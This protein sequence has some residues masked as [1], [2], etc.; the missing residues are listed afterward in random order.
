MIACSTTL[1]AISFVIRNVSHSGYTIV[2]ARQPR[3]VY[4]ILDRTFNDNLAELG[5]G[6]KCSGHSGTVVCFMIGECRMNGV[7]S[8]IRNV[9]PATCVVVDRITSVFSGGVSGN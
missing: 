2:V 4:R 8:C 6:N 5:T 1:G 7:G 3:R 9:S